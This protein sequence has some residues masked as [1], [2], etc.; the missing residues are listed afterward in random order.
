MLTAAARR[1]SEVTFMGFETVELLPQ[2]N[3]AASG[4]KLG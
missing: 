4:T 2:Q 1:K 3:R